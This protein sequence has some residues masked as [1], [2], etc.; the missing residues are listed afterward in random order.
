MY[1]FVS[2]PMQAF[3][4]KMLETE[5]RA[6]W[7]HLNFLDPMDIF[8][9]LAFH[10]LGNTQRILYC[11]IILKEAW[12]TSTHGWGIAFSLWIKLRRGQWRWKLRMLWRLKGMEKSFLFSLASLSWHVDYRRRGVFRKFTLP[13]HQHLS[14]TL[15]SRRKKRWQ[16]CWVF[17]TVRK[18]KI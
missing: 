18:N 4:H 15:W 7:L 16:G 12:N 17:T 5:T 8:Q 10:F 14:R 9:F 6:L 2:F 3:T 1:V 13:I 11:G